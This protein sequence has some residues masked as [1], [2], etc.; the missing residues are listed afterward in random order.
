[1]A[2][3]T[4]AHRSGHTRPVSARLDGGSPH[5]Q[6]LLRQI[7]RGVPRAQIKDVTLTAPPEDF[8]PADATWI[9]F[10]VV[11]SG[12]AENVRGFWQALVVAG[13]FRDESASRGLP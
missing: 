7:L 1:A 3:A 9:A 4:A 13:L 2:F 12:P 11:A 5:Q 8:E 10:D 6:T